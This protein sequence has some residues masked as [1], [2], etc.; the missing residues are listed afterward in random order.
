[1]PISMRVRGG[2]GSD[3]NGAKPLDLAE[4][5]RDKAAVAFVTVA[6]FALYLTSAFVLQSREATALFGAD[7]GLYV[8]LAHGNAA[9]RVTRFHPLTTALITS[10]MHLLAPLGRWIG[11]AHILKGL[12]AAVGAL[13]VWAAMRAFSALVARRYVPWLGAIYATSLGC[14]YFASIEESKIISATLASLYLASYVTLRGR[15]R[16][17]RAVCL[18]GILL[19]ACLNEIVAGLLVV[20]PVVDALCERGINLRS[21]G[22]LVP[23]ALVVPGTLVFLEFVVNGR[24][25]GASEDPEQASHVSMLLFYLADNDF[26]WPTTS[27]FLSNWLL[28]NFAAPT[29]LATH[30]FPQWPNY[31]GFFPPGL[32][33]YLTSPWGWGLAGVFAVIATASLFMPRENERSRLATGLLLGLL[34]YTILR[35]GFFYLF[36]P[37]ECL[38]F[39]SSATLAHMV[40]VGV[41]FVTSQFPYRSGI[42]RLGAT[43]LF[44]NNAIF[45]FGL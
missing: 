45:I 27:T 25:A 2:D 9:D 30:A 8:W 5:A 11:P 44:V 31:Q 15:W 6:A 38:L 22:W 7:T 41:P 16:Q 35:G 4:T 42:I 14:W 36:D 33:N 39:S 10:W 21:D 3:L 23:H 29:K 18:T 32:G 1:M 40:L 26:D 37:N 20:V 12:F 43:L 19:L 34:A 28:F 24:I 13:G 17:S